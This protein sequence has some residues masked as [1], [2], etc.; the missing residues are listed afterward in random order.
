MKFWT[1]TVLTFISLAS[2]CQTEADCPYYEL[3]YETHLWDSTVRATCDNGITDTVV[4]DSFP[5]FPGGRASFVKFLDEK[6]YPDSF[7]VSGKVR[8]VYLQFCVERNGW[9]TMVRP[10]PG[11][12]EM[13]PP[14]FNKEAIRLMHS[15][16]N[17]KPGYMN[18]QPVPVHIVVLLL[19]EVDEPRKWKRILKKNRKRLIQ[20]G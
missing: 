3:K 10:Y 17:W 19:F 14:D 7:Y 2:F 12:E 16:P 8:K 4:L 20:K 13:S 11:T 18:G 5:A 15:S 9:V 6:K 1:A